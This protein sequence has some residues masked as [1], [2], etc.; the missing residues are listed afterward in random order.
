M[1][2]CTV[3]IG[4]LLWDV[5]PSG[6]RLG[7]AP[8][9]FAAHCFHLGADACL[10]SA[11]GQDADGVEL[12]ETMS[13]LGLPTAWIQRDAGHPTGTVQVTLNAQG[14]PAYEICRPVA[15]DFVQWTDDLETLAAEAG[16]V[17]FG[18]LAQRGDATRKTIQRFLA[19]VP[20]AA[21]RIFDVNLRQDFYSREILETSLG[22]ANVVKLSDEELPVLAEMFGFSGEAEAQARQLLERF[23]LRHVAYTRGANGSLLVGPAITSDCPG[24]DTHVVDTVG[25]GDSFTA[26]LCVGLLHGLPLDDIH[27]WANRVAAFVCSQRGATPSLPAE[28]APHAFIPGE[29]VW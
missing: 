7:G 1:A 12:C 22:L 10:V 28:L 23:A 24:V 5:F 11:V 13:G 6:R 26:A 2:K 20:D 14:H 4:E 17:C 19:A 18:S 9:N 8:A 29:H 27:V 25:A 15:W 16:A 3:G 21:L